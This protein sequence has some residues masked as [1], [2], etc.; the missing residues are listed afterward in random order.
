MR[1]WGG[2]GSSMTPASLIF[3]A[4]LKTTPQF[5]LWLSIPSLSVHI[6]CSGATILFICS[7]PWRAPWPIAFCVFK[8]MYL[9]LFLFLHLLSLC[10]SF[11]VLMPIHPSI[12]ACLSHPPNLSSSLSPAAT[13]ALQQGFAVASWQCHTAGFKTIMCHWRVHN[14]G[15]QRRWWGAADGRGGGEAERGRGWNATKVASWMQAYNNKCYVGMACTWH[16]SSS[17]KMHLADN[18]KRGRGWSNWRMI[19]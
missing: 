18:R 2:E 6:T 12:P 19:W 1:G 5:Q 7:N 8:N 17:S 4:T 3:S 13:R 14:G 10:L 15:R 9:L 16:L 11:I